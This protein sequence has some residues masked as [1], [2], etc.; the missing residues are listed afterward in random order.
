MSGHMVDALN[1]VAS[2][3]QKRDD[4]KTAY[5]QWLAIWSAG[6]TIAVLLISGLFIFR[7]MARRVQQDIDTLW[8]FNENLK[9]GG[10]IKGSEG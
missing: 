7:P 5:L 10:R 3:Y 6:S 9:S 2:E 8:R 4:Q 1:Q